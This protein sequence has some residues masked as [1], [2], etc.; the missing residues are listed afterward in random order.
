MNLAFDIKACK[1]DLKRNVK[2]DE[3]DFGLYMDIQ[4]EK[5]GLWQRV[6]PDQAKR[7]A[8]SWQGATPCVLGAG[9]LSDLLGDVT[10]T[11]QE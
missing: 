2:L 10:Q 5:D 8:R 7:V 4:T 11:S 1:P 6:K 3:D 9:D